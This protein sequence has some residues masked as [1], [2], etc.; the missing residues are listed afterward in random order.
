MLN[1]NNVLKNGERGPS[2]R[3]LQEQLQDLGYGVD[4]D[5]IFGRQTQMA[6]KA[7][8]T[9]HRLTVDG[10]VGPRTAAALEEARTESSRPR[11]LHPIES[12]MQQNPTVKTSQDFINYCYRR[13]GGTWS[14]AKEIANEFGL[15]LNA[16][17]RNRRASLT[18]WVP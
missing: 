5:G 15:D 9:H 8:Q 2:V 18:T 6:V 1:G 12:F 4:V 14:A 17:S 11:A 16:L 3:V 7:F 13:G 10:V